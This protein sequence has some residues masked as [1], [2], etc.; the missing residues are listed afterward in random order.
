MTSAHR[1]VMAAMRGDAAGPHAPA[2]LEAV[3]RTEAVTARLLACPDAALMLANATIYLDLLGTVVIA[4]MWLKLG[5]AAEGADSFAAGKRAAAA[6]FFG[7]ELP[8]T[9][10]QAALMERL[11]DTCLRV[12]AEAL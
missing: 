5:A 9:Q 4:W 10:A 7:Y 12:A 6:Y 2:L 8:A 1:E 3:A 11:D